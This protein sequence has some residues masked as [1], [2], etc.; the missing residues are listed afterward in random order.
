MPK[1]PKVEREPT[2]YEKLKMMEPGERLQRIKMPTIGFQIRR[3][4]WEKA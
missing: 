2:E 3:F 4:D 1:K